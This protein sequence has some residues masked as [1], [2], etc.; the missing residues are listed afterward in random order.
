M[1]IAGADA[2]ECKTCLKCGSLHCFARFSVISFHAGTTE[3]F[4]N[5]FR[6]SQSLAFVLNK[7]RGK[8]AGICFNGV[9]ERVNS[10]VSSGF[11]RHAEGQTRVKRNG[12]GQEFI[13]DK[14]LLFVLILVRNDRKKRNL[15]AGTGSCWN[16]KKRNALFAA[17]AE[18]K[19]VVNVPFGICGAQ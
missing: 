10:R 15:R 6:S 2:P 13:A 17:A 1:N 16:S 14:R 7:R 3:I 4:E 12:M 18:R 19:Q 5:L 8:K 9:S 11:F